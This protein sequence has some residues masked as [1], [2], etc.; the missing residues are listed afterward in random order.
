MK[1]QKTALISGGSGRTVKKLVRLVRLTLF[2][3]LLCK[4]HG[5]K[6]WNAKYSNTKGQDAKPGDFGHCISEG[7]F[8]N[9]P[10][11]S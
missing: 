2:G 7:P 9:R 5:I 11:P 6:G 3:F 8:W 10:Q 4:G 1:M